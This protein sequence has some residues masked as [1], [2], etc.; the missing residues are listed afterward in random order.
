VLAEYEAGPRSERIAAARAEVENLQAQWRLAQ[1][2]HARRDQLRRGGVVSQEEYDQQAFGLQAAKARLD[3]AQRRLDELEAGTRDEQ[4]E[5]QRAVVARLDSAL[6]QI[7]LDLEDSQLRAPFDGVIAARYLDEGT[8]ADQGMAVFRILDVSALEAWIG[9][10]PGEVAGIH[11][12][13]QHLLVIDGREHAATVSRI[14]PELDPRT[15]T[16]SVVF[17]LDAKPDTLVAGQVVRMSHAVD[18]GDRGFWLP[19]GAL[20]RGDRGLWSVLAVVPGGDEWV[21][22]VERRDVELLHTEADRVFVRGTL[23]PH[24]Q[25]VAHGTHRL[26][27]GQRVVTI[28]SIDANQVVVRSAN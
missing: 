27:P 6:Q 18:R 13:Q 23:A 10:P 11:A 14:L 19:V 1:V 15:R 4:I 17:Q 8:V 22:V 3:A 20:T 2:T 21:P 25:V 5:A 16:R 24:D 26:V 9:L 12:G 7:G 28:D